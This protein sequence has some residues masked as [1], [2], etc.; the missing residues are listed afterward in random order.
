MADIIREDIIS[1]GWDIDS[2]PLIQMQ[3]ELDEIK[4]KL[5]GGLGDEEFDE[6]KDSVNGANDSLGD[7]QKEANKTKDNLGKAQQASEKL[8]NKLTDLGK[9]GFAAL[10]KIAS[11]TFKALAAGVAAVGAAVGKIAYEAVQAYAD[12]EQL[13]GGVETLF[14]D[15]AG[16]VMKYANNAYKTAGLSANQY[17]ET[18]TSFSASLLQS[19]DGDT[20][21]A[22][23]YADMAISDMA[24][25]ANKMG[26]DMGSIQYAYQGFAK[27]NYTMLDNLKL[28][29]GG[30]K[31]EMQRLVKDAAKI[32]K[33]VDANSMS[34]ANIVKAIHAV[35]EEMGIYGTTQKEA[36]KTI[37]GSLNAMKSSWSNLLTAMASGENL[38]QCIDNMVSSVEIFA[39][40]VMPVA[41]KALMGLGTVVEKL[42]PII[43][44]KLPDLADKL[45]P[46][47]I[48]ATI[49]LAKGLVKALPNI[50]KTVFQ[51]VG[52][53]LTEQFPALSKLGGFFKNAGEKIAKFTPILLGLVGAFLAFKKIKSIGSMFGGLFGG[54]SKG[55][56]GKKGGMFSGL[57]S[58]AKMK[59]TTVLKGMAN[60]AII[61]GGMAILT[62]AFMAVA[63]H[64]AKIG[65]TGAFIKM[66]L[67]MTALG[68]VGGV[69]A[70]FGEIAGKIQV[71][72]VLK[73]LANMAIMIAGMSAL[74]LLV[75]AL[76]LI[77]FDYGTMTAIIGL[78]GLLGLVGTALTIFAGIVG[79]I[80]IA[81][82]A[83]G[84][85]NMA[86]VIA[87]MDALFLLIGATSLINFNYGNMLK[88]IGL[89]GLLGTVGAV[90]TTF[91]G[92]IGLIPMPVV[93]IGLAN[94]TLVLGAVTALIIAFGAL[95]KVEGIQEFVSM[96]GDLLVEI[97][98]IIGRIAGALIGG[99][100]A[101]VS[102]A[103]PTIGENL[104]KFGEN[105]KPLFNAIQ[106]TDMG[107]LGSFFAAIGGFL[108]L[109]TGNNILDTLTSW[110]TGNPFEKLGKNLTL[111]AESARGFFQAVVSY[112]EEGFN[113]AKLMFECLSGLSNLPLS[114]GLTQWFGGEINFEKIASGL[115]SFAD[116]GVKSFFNMAN[117]L[118]VEAFDH[119][120][121]LFECL[122]GLSSL[123]NTDGVAQWFTGSVN[124]KEIADG[125][126]ALGA[127]GVKKFFTM[128]ADLSPKAFENT[129]L[130]F[131]SLSGI[132]ES[133]PKEDNWWDKLWGTEKQSLGD[134][135][136]D[137][138]NFATKGATFFKLVDTINI[139][140]MNGL[141]E[142]LKNAGGVT[143]E[144]LDKVFSDAIDSLVTKISELPQKMGDA[145]KN[146]SSHLSDG[147]VEM[148]KEA[149]KASVAPVNKLLDGA[150]HIL[151]EFGSKKKVI[152]WTPYANGT[153]GH[154]GGNALVNDGRG[155]ELVQMPNGNTFI[156]NGRNV[157]M[158]N[159]P[160]GMKVLPAEQTA[161]IMGKNSPTFNYANGI[162]NIDVWSFYDNAKGLVDKIT[163]NISYNGL[164]TLASNV[165]QS[166][167]STFAGEMPAWIEK[168]FEEGGQSIGSYVASKGVMQWLPTVVRAL[169]MEG[170]YSLANV[171]RTLFQMRTESGGNPKAINL[172]DS[173]AKKGIPSKGLMQVIDPTFNAYAREGFDKNIYDPLSNI[174]ASIRYAVSRYGSLTKAF[175]GKGYANGGIATSPSIFGEDGAEMA[176]PLSRNKR[177][178]GVS[179]WAQTGEML[180]LSY[181]PESGGD[182]YVST[183]VES[184]TYAP[185]LHFHISG[186]NDDRTF[187]RKVKKIVTEAIADVIDG[188][189][190]SNPK[191]KEV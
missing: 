57:E 91:A 118:P 75:G 146:N 125:L 68:V 135:A 138:E 99:V 139:K 108:L 33:S 66:A 96:G 136:T 134:I 73:G 150:N 92:A 170:Q 179:L 144:N 107:A 143:T 6:L 50:I 119:G 176:I 17:M 159:A 133:L 61:F 3:K 87:G 141:W 121:K 131:K 88:V 104:G 47:L 43:A 65:D 19:L 69:L 127:D 55:A 189:E 90:L 67:I 64:L 147:M 94:L 186:S 191:L 173:N 79:L 93:L 129:K 12:F 86:I 162:G 183:S 128:A 102:K 52:E 130:L 114:G 26:T 178:R 117:S 59:T 16:T 85:A 24:D 160:Q 177:N 169:K 53:I 44:D 45:L 112:P 7:M 41:E 163:E 120:K 168:L 153:S 25:N 60:L 84:L 154:K 39:G 155:A 149:V 184:N 145:L 2:N 74:F 181:T 152:E 106:G 98:N 115:A 11:V 190:R 161:Q 9:K 78:L 23:K 157:F 111:F 122:A 166:M 77:K 82:V 158:P 72:T 8:K 54:G 123:P 18:V 38:D 37:T 5:G 164:S 109:V 30:T 124:Y 103:L 42:A 105:I 14:K 51:T 165:G 132:S 185:Q 35:Q 27:Q 76:S 28:G 97:F 148:W 40:N 101:E 187:A 171:A 167:V 175:R 71:T 110:F 62:A 10:K 100:G 36:E 174:L 58:L 172:W 63:P 180:G 83:L 21:K 70:K 49:S 80:P 56:G 29:Y 48:K 46:P 15:N 4:K 1:V 81:T 13:K 137:L 182:E 34:Y 95:S 22:A 142:S 31:E 32:D 89:I 20:A 140:N 113:K 116:E 151:K 156:P 126:T 188:A